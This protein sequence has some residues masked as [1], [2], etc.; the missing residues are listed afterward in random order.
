VLVA[1]NPTD[2]HIFLSAFIGERELQATS[3]GIGVRTPRGTVQIMDPDA[4]RQHFGV[5]APDVS[6]GA[7]LAAIRFGVSNLATARD[8]LKRASIGVS[9]VLG[10]VAVGPGAAMGATLVFEP[11]G[12]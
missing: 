3:T 11:A 5:K 8:A 7:R 9:E 1:E 6:G 2:H 12:G 4:F 10:R